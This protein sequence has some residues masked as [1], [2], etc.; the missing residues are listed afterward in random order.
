MSESVKLRRYQAAV[1]DEPVVMTLSRPG[2]RGVV[3]PTAAEPCDLSVIPA[4][5]RRK[6]LPKL[7]EMSEPDV[8]RHYLHLSQQTLGMMGISLFGTCTMKY[9]ARV[10]EAITARDDVAQLHPRQPDSTLQGSLQVMHNLDL[11]LRA[12][13]GMD[14]F[15]FQAA[16]GADAAFLHVCVTRAYHAARGE[17]E[18][19]DEIITSIQSHPCNPATAATAGFK[20]IT[21]PLEENGYPSLEALK[22]AVSPRT[23]ALMINNPDDMGI[24]NPDIAEWVRVVKEAGGLCFY[25]HANFNGVMSKVRARD[26]GFD[27]C[28]FMLHKTFGAPKGGGGPAV[29]AYGCSEELIPYLPGPLLVEEPGGFRLEAGSELGIGRVREFLGNLPQI[30]KAYAWVRAM[31]IEG[32]AE[33]SDLSVLANNYMGKQL[34]GIRGVTCS[35]PHIK[36]WR[37]EMTRYSL[38]T[39]ERETGISAYDVQNRMVD[40]GVDAFWLAHEPWVI[41]QPF[42]PEAGEMWSKEDIDYWIAVLAQV[43]QEAYD[44]PD[45]VRTAPHNHPIGRLDSGPLEDPDRWATT[46]RAYQR[47]YPDAL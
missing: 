5:M 32:I 6:T 15:V 40:Y 18:T 3:F 42:T 12:L 10:N 45:L 46:W 30:I 9:N 20:I 4:A 26:L 8:L 37:L 47:K 14:R 1:W 22:A 33:A 34:A 31:G 2:R 38:E 36:A 35:H 17:L 11:N 19:R 24:Y 23:A 29:G 21:L 44:N 43:C 13:S 28:M 16:G 27:A 7:P 41:A 25:D 39:L